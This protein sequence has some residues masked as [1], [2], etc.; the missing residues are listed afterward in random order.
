M[1]KEAEKSQGLTVQKQK[2]GK[3]SG[4]YN[5]SEKSNT[6]LTSDNK[7]PEVSFESIPDSNLRIATIDYGTKKEYSVALQ[8]FGLLKNGEWFKTKK[9]AEYT[10]KQLILIERLINITLGINMQHHEQTMHGKTENK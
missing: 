10:A 9:D 4:S 3:P 1:K 2:S 5:K 8:N 7:Q 6:S